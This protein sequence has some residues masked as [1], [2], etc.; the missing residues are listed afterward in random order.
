MLFI[1]WSFLKIKF[2]FYL[3]CLSHKIIKYNKLITDSENAEEKV[4]KDSVETPQKETKEDKE[5]G[6]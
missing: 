3:N 6:K 5:S 2:L 1:L 4:H